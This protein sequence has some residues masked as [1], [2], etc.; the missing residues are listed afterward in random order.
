MSASGRALGSWPKIA[1]DQQLFPP[2][3]LTLWL[4]PPPSLFIAFDQMFSVKIFVRLC[5]FVCATDGFMNAPSFWKYK[6][7]ESKEAECKVFTVV[8]SPVVLE[9]CF[10]SNTVVIIESCIAL[11][12]TNAPT[13]VSTT[14]T[15]SSTL[16]A[17]PASEL[18]VPP[19]M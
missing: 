4:L 12:V 9:T 16:N 3:L 8:E 19:L 10:S 7:R 17:E 14:V 2:H 13:C 18:I 5:V 6:Y 15:V 11:H 1:N